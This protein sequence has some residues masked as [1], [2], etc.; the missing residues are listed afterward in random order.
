MY[1]PHSINILLSNCS[2][3][4]NH[5]PIV[6]LLS[7]GSLPQGLTSGCISDCISASCT[8]LGTWNLSISSIILAMNKFS[9]SSCKQSDRF[10][11]L[12]PRL[13]LCS[14]SELEQSLWFS[15]A[16]L[17]PSRI[18]VDAGLTG[19]VTATLPPTSGEGYPYGLPFVNVSNVN[20]DI[21]GLHRRY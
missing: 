17:H 20:G 21:L 14:A 19:V 10:T 16:E 13:W 6:V 11:A 4:K 12:L 1:R 9:F 3:F 18:R 8:A 5:D 15:G 7:D 2:L